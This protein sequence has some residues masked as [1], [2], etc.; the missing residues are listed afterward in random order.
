MQN[1]HGVTLEV[2]EIARVET[3]LDRYPRAVDRLFTAAERAYCNPKRKAAQHYTARLAAK[4]AA[5]RL[6]G[7]GM[8]ADFEVVRDERGAPS[9][10]LRGRAA[11]I[12]G[13][14]RWLLSLSH[15]AGVAAAY[16]ARL[17]GLG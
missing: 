9:L 14:C 3:L 13:D 4:V 15:D 6:L 12:A 10:A 7:G 1:E 2:M 5:R 17:D 11:E 8:L 16:V